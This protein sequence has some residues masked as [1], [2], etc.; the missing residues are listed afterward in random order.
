MTSPPPPL[1]DVVEALTKDT[2]PYL[3]CDE[4]FDAICAYVERSA[5]DEG[6]DDEAMRKHLLGC[7]ACA[8]EAV[9]LAELGGADAALVRGSPPGPRH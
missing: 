1:A 9:A 4:C 7:P 8:D 6:Y 2:D 3:S 5:A